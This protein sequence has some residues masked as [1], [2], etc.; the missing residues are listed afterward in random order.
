MSTN[1]AVTEIVTERIARYPPQAR[2]HP[3]RRVRLDAPSF[4]ASKI[5]VKSIDPLELAFCILDELQLTT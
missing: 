5:V 2:Y 1:F 4:L 3:G